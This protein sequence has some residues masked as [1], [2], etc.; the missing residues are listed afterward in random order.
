MPGR[1]RHGRHSE[2]RPVPMGGMTRGGE[3]PVTGSPPPQRRQQILLAVVA[4]ALVIVAVD[5]WIFPH[6]RAHAATQHDP[7]NYPTPIA[8]PHASPCQAP[9]HTARPP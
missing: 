5:R 4:A 3:A 9:A 6:Y 7:H 8:P 2:R 1:M